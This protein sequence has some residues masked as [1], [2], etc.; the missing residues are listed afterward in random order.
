M[1]CETLL[2]AVLGVGKYGCKTSKHVSFCFYTKSI[3]KACSDPQLRMIFNIRSV[4]ISEE[5]HAKRS[6][7]KKCPDVVWKF[8]LWVQV[9]VHVRSWCL[10]TIWCRN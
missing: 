8:F 5:R 2:A 3:I 7:V 6:I 9:F 4:K 10:Q 1:I